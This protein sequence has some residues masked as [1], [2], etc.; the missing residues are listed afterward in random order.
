MESPSCAMLRAMDDLE[1]A[2]AHLNTA[3]E[4]LAPPAQ[5]LARDALSHLERAR[6]LTSSGEV[7]GLSALT[8]WSLRIWSGHV[9]SRAD[10][11]NGDWQSAPA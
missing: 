3:I 8:H 11:V 6:S 4:H 10:S 7:S 1:L 9:V 5:Q 2:I